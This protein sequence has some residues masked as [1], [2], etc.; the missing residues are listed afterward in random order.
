MVGFDI[1]E[2]QEEY[3]LKEKLQ[4]ILKKYLAKSGHQILKLSF[5]SGCPSNSS[6]VEVKNH[7]IK[8]VVSTFNASNIP[9]PCISIV[10]QKPLND[11]F[12]SVEIIYFY[13]LHNA[14]EISFKQREHLRYCILSSNSD[15]FLVTSST[16]FYSL[17][18]KVNAEKIFSQVY[19]AFKSIEDV[20]IQEGFDFSDV[21]RQWTYI[22]DV[23]LLEEYDTGIKQFYQIYNDV[24][25]SFFDKY[26][27]ENGYMAATG[28]GSFAG[29]IT[30]E[31]IAYKKKDKKS[32]FIAPVKNPKQIN[33]YEYTERKL[34]GTPLRGFSTKTT[35]KFER[36]KLLYNNQHRLLFLSGTS[37]VIGEDTVYNNET[38]KQVETTVQNIEQVLESSNRITKEGKM[39]TFDDIT[40]LRVY[41]RNSTDLFAIK[42]FL[43]SKFPKA[44]KLFLLSMIC[45]DD[46][47]VEIEGVGYN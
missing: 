25:S 21:V 19:L 5:F 42:L 23:L 29:I 13:D 4:E 20:L 35:P 16:P 46:L 45:R 32:Y 28:I 43:N 12:C 2:I 7:I 11:S 27:F 40:L 18:S 47:N 26:N 44:K 1:I 6:L 14:Y 10:A 24:R 38:F 9:V 30:T 33:A 36:G 17:A 3:S 39:L 41:L 22:E 34:I 15:T 8:E 37:S 31:V